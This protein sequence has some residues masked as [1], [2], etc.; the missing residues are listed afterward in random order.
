MVLYPEDYTLA[1]IG[2]GFDPRT[3]WPG[4][5]PRTHGTPS[6]S[7]R[8]SPFPSLQALLV[9]CPL[10]SGMEKPPEIDH[11]F[12]ASGHTFDSVLFPPR[13]ASPQHSSIDCMC[14]SVPSDLGCPPGHS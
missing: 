14:F 10:L 1:I 9:Q 2:F 6:V 7:T 5:F 4:L 3:A 11:V 13:W 12:C 8:Y